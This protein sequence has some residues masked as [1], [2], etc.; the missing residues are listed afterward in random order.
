MKGTTV[1]YDGSTDSITVNGGTTYSVSPDGD[2]K[3]VPTE[4]VYK[5]QQSEYARQIDEI[6]KREVRGQSK[7]GDQEKKKELEDKMIELMKLY[8]GL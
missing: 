4:E 3:Y 6:E 5:K 8:K 2:T 7:P 1:S